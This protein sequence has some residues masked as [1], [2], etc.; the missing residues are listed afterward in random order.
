MKNTRALGARAEAL[1][2]R[3]LEK[4]GFKIVATNWRGRVGGE[5]DLIAREG[6]T[7]CFVEVR[8]RS[9]PSSVHPLET[10]DARKQARLRR[11][12]LAYLAKNKPAP[13]RFDVVAIVGDSVELLRG[14]FE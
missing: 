11:A 14:A 12:A 7:V 8:F 3:H 5:V 6:S 9:S 2:R 10:I 13:L 4:L 1:A